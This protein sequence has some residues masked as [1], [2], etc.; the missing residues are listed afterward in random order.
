MPRTTIETR[1]RYSETD[2][3]RRLRLRSLLALCQDEFHLSDLGDGMFSEESLYTQDAEERAWFVSAWHFLWKDRPVDGEKLTLSQ[4]TSKKNSV[5]LQKDFLVESKT[6]GEMAYV[7]S[8]WLRFNRRTQKIAF[9]TEEEL[10]EEVLPPVALP[11]L[12]RTIRSEAGGE[13]LFPLELRESETD[14]NGH[15]N[16]IALI[17]ILEDALPRGSRSLDEFM[18]G[19]FALQGRL[20]FRKQIFRGELLFP[21]RILTKDKILLILQGAEGDERVLLELRKVLSK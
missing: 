11:A 21:R 8:S 5:L 17:G 7:R 16:N 4:W 14:E 13:M 12:Q 10:R 15:G 18:E 6:R 20:E 9:F 2:A 19:D 3:I 1:V